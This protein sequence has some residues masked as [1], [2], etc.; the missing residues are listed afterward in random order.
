MPVARDIGQQSA[1]GHTRLI[2]YHTRTDYCAI[3]R[4]LEDLDNRGCSHRDGC[5]AAATDVDRAIDGE[6]VFLLTERSIE[7]E[8]AFCVVG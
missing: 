1:I 4:R 7:G 5:I 8:T 6:A 2:V 3:T